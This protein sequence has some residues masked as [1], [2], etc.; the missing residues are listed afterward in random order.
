MTFNKK[1]I[2]IVFDDRCRLCHKCVD[3]VI[4]KDTNDVFRFTGIESEVAQ[5]IK[6][7]FNVSLIDSILVFKKNKIYSK[8]DALITIVSELK[9]PF[10]MLSLIVLFPKPIRNWGYNIVS[11]YRYRWYGKKDN[12]SFSHKMIEKECLHL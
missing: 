1:K 3:F 8:S 2:I 9:F 11:K 10:N 5:L 4:R 12:C 6:R 7:K